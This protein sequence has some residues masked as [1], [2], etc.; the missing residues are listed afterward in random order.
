MH[1]HR[2]AS[3]RPL[4][5]FGVLSAVPTFL[6]VSC[7]ATG[8][9]LAAGSILRSVDN[10]L[11]AKSDDQYS[12]GLSISYVGPPEQ[13]FSDT[14]LPSWIGGFLDDHWPG[15]A[16]DERFVIYS[17]SQRLF[18]PTDLEATEVVEDDLPYSALFYATATAGTQSADELDAASL[19]L[20]VVGPLALGE[21]V[22]SSVHKLTGSDDPK[23]WDNQLENEPLLNVGF[24]HR[25]RL[26]R[27][28]QSSGIGGDLLAGLSASAGNLETQATLAST[29]RLGWRVPSN[30]QMQSEFLAEDSLGL[31]PWSPT[32][33]K[34]FFYAFAGFAGTLLANA[35]YLD[36]NTFADSH[37]VEHDPYVLRGSL[38]L[39]WQY[40]RLLVSTVYERATLPWDQP[41][42]LDHE[43][44]LR[45]GISWDF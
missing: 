36:G 29:V 5:F 25:Q 15:T 45:F 7:T 4:H 30:F 39:A 12:S 37:S 9:T 31:R 26:M 24:E 21:E 6:F 23:G 20:G 11:F 3:A 19:S 17:I 40:G 16:E 44:Y 38:G 14:A 10:D 27:F 22:Q 43:D 2:T 28:G 42:G 35:I 13:T 8:G 41:E 33:E 18:T 34:P 32:P 1:P